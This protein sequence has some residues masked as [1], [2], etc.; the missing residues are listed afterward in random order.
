[1]DVRARPQAPQPA[2]EA[3][4]HHPISPPEAVGK[5]VFALPAYV[6]NGL[7]GLRILGS[8]MAASALLAFSFALF[9][10]MN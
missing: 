3:D 8:W 7:I 6:S 2:A 1:M 5:G 9:V 4:P 10:Q